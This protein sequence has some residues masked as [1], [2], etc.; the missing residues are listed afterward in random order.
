M[1]TLKLEAHVGEDGVLNLKVPIDIHD[2]DVDVTIVIEPLKNRIPKTA[3]IIEFKGRQE[4][5]SY[6]SDDPEVIQRQMRDEWA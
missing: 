1:Q 3:N 5:S 4:D 6:F 2:Q